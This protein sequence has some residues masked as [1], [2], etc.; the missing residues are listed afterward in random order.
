MRI[1]NATTGEPSSSRLRTGPSSRPIARP[2]SAFGRNWRRCSAR[3]SR[4]A[5]AN[6]P[7]AAP[8]R[9]RHRP[10]TDEDL[11][12]ALAQYLDFEP[13][14]KLA[15]L[16]HDSLR[17]RAE[18]LVELLEMKILISRTPGLSSVAH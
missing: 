7:N 13:L 16:Q 2:Y 6:A 10:M 11:V 4:K 8:T 12:N 1:T 5:L 18:S 3:P 14:E 15:L 17:E 9:G